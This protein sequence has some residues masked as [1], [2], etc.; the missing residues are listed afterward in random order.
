MLLFI[1]QWA[2]GYFICVH[3][4]EEH[5]SSSVFEIVAC[6]MI[7]M[8][9]GWLICLICIWNGLLFSQSKVS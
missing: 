8:L 3:E 5:D 6:L 2:I 1:I 7:S 9:M 4:L